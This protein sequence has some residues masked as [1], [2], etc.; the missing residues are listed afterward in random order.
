MRPRLYPRSHAIDDYDRRDFC[1]LRKLSRTRE[2]IVSLSQACIS[3][4][5][6]VHKLAFNILR[7]SDDNGG[8]S[9]LWPRSSGS[10]SLCSPYL[11]NYPPSV[12]FMRGPHAALCVFRASFFQVH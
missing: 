9:I 4:L 1:N 10:V 8:G 2:E 3:S 7:V 6:T 5:F 12:S 11:P